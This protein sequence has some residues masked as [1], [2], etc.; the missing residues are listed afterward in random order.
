[1]AA[2]VA[3]AAVVVMPPQAADRSATAA[4]SAAAVRGTRAGVE[5]DTNIGNS[6]FPGSAGPVGRR[7]AEPPGEPLPFRG[8]Q[9]V[10]EPPHV[11]EREAGLN[12]GVGHDRVVDEVAVAVERR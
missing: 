7:A 12:D 9:L 3:G 1:M 8:D 4:S 2:A 6:S 11:V 10:G 5:G